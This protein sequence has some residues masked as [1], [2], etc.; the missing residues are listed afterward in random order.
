MRRPLRPVRRGLL[1]AAPLALAVSGLVLG[2]ALAA[3]TLA[4]PAPGRVSKL[5][6]F[7]SHISH[8]IIL[9]QENH[10]YDNLFGEYCLK[11][12]PYCSSAANGIPPGV[13]VPYVP[14]YPMFGCLKPYNF[15]AAYESL[16]TDLP[17]DWNASHTAY[18]GGAMNGFYAAA[19]P[20][21]LGH[22]NAS[23]VPVYYDLAE[24]YGLADDFFSGALSYS[25]PNHWYDLA[26]APPNASLQNRLGGPAG[27]A[28][29]HTYLNEANLTATIE[30]QLKGTGITW[31]YYDT[32]LS[33]YSAAIQVPSGSAYNYWDPLMAQAQSYAPGEASHFVDR[34]SFFTDARL[35]TLPDISFV[36]PDV[37]DSDHPPEN[38]TAGQTWVASVV[39]ALEASPE[40]N[41]SV[42]F[43]TW[44]EYGGFYDHV[45][46][47]DVSSA[48]EGFRVPLIAV[49]PWARQGYVDPKNLTFESLLHL[50]QKRFSLGCLGPQDC[51]AKLPLKMFNFNRPTPRAP[52][53][54]SPFA[55]AS[56][57]MPLE[58]SGALPPF[59]GPYVPPPGTGVGMS[60]AEAEF[61]DPSVDWS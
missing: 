12:G 1:L 47:P 57:P 39:D 53:Y 5:A 11:A 4:G 32:R 48:G 55:N 35:G 51:E 34:S 17:H 20:P 41:S 6:L 43:I 30:T 7:D 19:G 16:P 38:I 36:I 29:D 42:L 2:G 27:A 44:D 52:I 60:V 26:A 46:P 22:Y 25:L 40:W 14:S 37:A 33:N 18:D 61:A 24:E 15:S 50:T 13:C 58:S 9:M 54:I 8:I 23:T 10:A 45:R 3:P 49:S 31:K 56:Y 21:S 28:I 59:Y